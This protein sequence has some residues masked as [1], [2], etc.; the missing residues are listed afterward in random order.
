MNNL[1][2]QLSIDDNVTP[3]AT[4]AHFLSDGLK[5]HDMLLLAETLVVTASAIL[6]IR[7]CH[8]NPPSGINWLIAPAILVSAAFIPTALRR[9]KLSDIGIVFG[10]VRHSLVVLGWTCLAVFPAMFCGLWLLKTCGLNLPLRPVPPQNQEYVSWL[11]YQF[12]YVAVAEEVFFRGY[13]QG[14]IQRFMSLAIKRRS[15]LRC[16]VILVISAACFA[17]AHII[18]KGQMIS[19]LIF[20]PGLLLGWLFIRTK[21]LLAPILFHALANSYYCLIAVVLI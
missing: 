13:V 14:N 6:A 11:F 21:S 2:G 10:Q 15:T 8:E 18:V 17:A 7:V 3:T 16:W 20:L 19:A 5:R 12:M 9:S 1:S 4:S